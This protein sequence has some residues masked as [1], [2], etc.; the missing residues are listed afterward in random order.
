MSYTPNAVVSHSFSFPE[1]TFTMNVSGSATRA[2]VGKAVALDP[3]APN[4]VKLAGDNDV[5]FGR[6][7]TFEADGLDGLKV[8]A[9]ARKFRAPIK[10][11]G[12]IAV[13]D[14][15][16]GSATAG[17]VKAAGTQPAG[18]AKSNLVIEVLTGNRVV[19][20]QL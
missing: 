6:L 4:T 13:G 20:E 12:A 16:V 2:D 17:V 19:V 18:N 9:V 7:E 15:V 8:G 14:Y 3:A 10:S 1:F 5:I 11:T